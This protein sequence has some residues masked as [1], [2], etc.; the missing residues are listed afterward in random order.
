[1][2][3]TEQSYGVIPFHTQRRAFLVIYQRDGFWAFPKGHSNT[4]ET[5]RETARRELYEETGVRAVTLLNTSFH[6]HFSYER[7]EE[8]YEKN[9]RYF[10]GL[11]Q[12]D[13]GAIRDE[14][15]L[16]CRF[17]SYATARELFTYPEKLVML[18]RVHEYIEKH[19]L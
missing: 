17:A 6:E 14:K 5:P 12:S 11:I 3:I 18:E 10:L 1:M 7:H 8:Q 4:E 19:D 13:P 9:V 2:P 16:Q 15:V